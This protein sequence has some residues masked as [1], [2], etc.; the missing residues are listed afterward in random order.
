[1]IVLDAGPLIALF[2]ASDRHHAA[3]VRFIRDL[4]EP[5]I[6]NLVVL[7]EACWVL[8]FST[9]AQRDC[10][11]WTRQVVRIDTEGAQDLPRVSEILHKYRDLPADFADATLVALCDRLGCYD[12]ASVDREFT[13]YRGA[14]RRRFRNRFPLARG[15]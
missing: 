13:I 4:R 12:V 9:Q 5:L 10:I 15:G 14:A 3:A 7:A 8:D 11:A 1:M 2:D 6:T